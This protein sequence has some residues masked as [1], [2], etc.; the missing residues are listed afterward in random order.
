MI[1]LTVGTQFPFDR[2]IRAVDNIFDQGL[3]DE[4]IFAQIGETSYKPRNFESVASLEKKVFDECFKKAS[5]VMSH[6]GVGTIT[7][8]L[9]NHKPLLVMPR[10]KRYKEHVNDHQVATA[11]KFEELGHI[12]AVYDVKDLPNGIRKLKNF[13][14][15]ERKAS[16]DA[17]AERIR[18]FL[19]KLQG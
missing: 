19:N 4:E 1:F 3:I 7:V 18:R 17:I 5:S 6:A 2:F 9:K 12:L 10:M 16:P 14:P 8:A 13:I 15:R 11:K